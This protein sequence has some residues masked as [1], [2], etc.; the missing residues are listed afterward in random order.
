[1]LM[2]GAC[3]RAERAV[4]GAARGGVVTEITLVNNL[5]PIPWLMLYLEVRILRSRARLRPGRHAR[6]RKQDFLHGQL[7]RVNKLRGRCHRSERESSLLRAGQIQPFRPVSGVPCLESPMSA[8]ASGT[9]H[10]WL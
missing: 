10:L 7:S 1:T 6:H 9:V 4:Q 2:K 8:V 3:D 5:A